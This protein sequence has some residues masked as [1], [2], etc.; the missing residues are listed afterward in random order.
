MNKSLAGSAKIG[1]GERFIE[2]AKNRALMPFLRDRAGPP[3]PGKIFV[4]LAARQTIVVVDDDLDVGTALK[5]ALIV[6]G[7]HVELFSSAVECLNAIVTDG[8]TC[9]VIDIDL[10]EDSGID[11]SREIFARGI[12]SPVIHMSG[13]GLPSVRQEALESGCAAFLD[14]PFAVPELVGVIEKV[15]RRAS[16]Y[17]PA[18]YQSEPG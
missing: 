3:A 9:F 14:K 12:K 10:G 13:S 2:A 11:L 16:S 4:M 17:L 7:Y 15:T 8:A 5:R 1:L 6:F 18:S